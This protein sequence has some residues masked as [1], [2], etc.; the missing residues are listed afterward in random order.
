MSTDTP[1]QDAIAD[2]WAQA[3]EEQAATVDQ[4][5]P[6]FD[7]DT[8][9]LAV[10]RRLDSAGQW[11]PVVLLGGLTP[12]ALVGALLGRGRLLLRRYGYA[13]ALTLA[14]PFAASVNLGER[15]APFFLDDIPRL[16]IYALPFLVALALVAWDRA[17]AHFEA[18]APRLVYGTGAA[19]AIACVALGIGAM[20]AFAATNWL[21]RLFVL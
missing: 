4:G 17:F 13:L 15:S 8:L 12:L 11:L 18:P 16:L 10:W 2:E 1:N 9:W 3:L 7:A 6:A 19:L 14:F 5:A 21:M 20:P